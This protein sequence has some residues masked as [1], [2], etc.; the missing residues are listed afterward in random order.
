M[1]EFNIAGA[2]PDYQRDVPA[3]LLP[4]TDLYPG[5]R[6]SSVSLYE[7]KPGDTSMGATYPDGEIRLN[8]YWFTREPTHLGK[9]ALHHAIVEVGGVQMGWHGPMVW[10]PRQLLTH[11]FG[12]VVWQ[13]LPQREVEEWAGGRW[14]AATREPYLAP[15]GYALTSRDE[16]FG[17]MFALVHL[18]F[19]TDAEVDDLDDLI[20]RLR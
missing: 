1:V 16:F 13:A 9:A 12:H 4:L 19:G 11:E 8:P 18:G 7:P 2:H 3:I 20:G 17:E 14:S 10:E 15:G 5:V 6:L